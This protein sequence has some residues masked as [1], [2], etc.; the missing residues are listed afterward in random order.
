MVAGFSIGIYNI[1]F[2][3]IMSTR[4]IQL[5]GDENIMLIDL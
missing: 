4:L 1:N 2:M 5:F 3:S